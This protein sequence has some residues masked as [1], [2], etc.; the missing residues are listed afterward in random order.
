MILVVVITC[1]TNSANGQIKSLMHKFQYAIHVGSSYSLGT[2]SEVYAVQTGIRIGGSADYTLRG[3]KDELFSI[4]GRLKIAYDRFG[5]GPDAK[6][7][8]D[9]YF[10][11]FP[12]QSIITFA[13]QF[14]LNIFHGNTENKVYLSAGVGHLFKKEIS[15]IPSF[16]SQL[17]ESRNGFNKWT[18]SFGAGSEYPDMFGRN[19]YLEG[20][21][22]VVLKSQSE[23]EDARLKYIS[24]EIGN[25]F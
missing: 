11:N 10:E 18:I 13:H 1:T 12:V 25:L 9:Y 23:N 14:K 3:E 19:I 21:Y 2:N 5:M 8:Y 7:R 17:Q 16:F 22:M 4:F 24:I 6:N 20:N 15:D